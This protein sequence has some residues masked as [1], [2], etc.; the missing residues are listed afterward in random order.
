MGVDGEEEGEIYGNVVEVD[1]DGEA[2][3]DDCG[4]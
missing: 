2:L 4:V 3:G 1:V